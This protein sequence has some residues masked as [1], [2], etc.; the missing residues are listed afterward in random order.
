MTLGFGM[1][2]LT[3]GLAVALLAGCGGTQSQGTGTSDMAPQSRAPVGHAEPDSS[4]MS[5]EA[6]SHDLLYVVSGSNVDVFT[7][8]G[9]TLVGTLTGFEYPL[10]LCS[11]SNG[12]VWIANDP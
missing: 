12:N 8:P 5:P 3:I 10:G 6:K 2:G 1:R 7:Y 4:W 9:G 11:D